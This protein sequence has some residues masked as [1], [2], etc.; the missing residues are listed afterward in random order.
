MFTRGAT[1]EKSSNHETMT[2]K[3]N[4]RK[5]FE[6]KRNHDSMDAKGNPWSHYG[7]LSPLDQLQPL[8]HPTD[9]SGEPR[10]LEPLLDC[11]TCQ[12]RRQCQLWKG[13]SPSLQYLWKI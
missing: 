5:H 12:V 1:S 4:Q 2:P 10:E 9:G 8:S 13:I 3:R 11:L 7:G 6:P